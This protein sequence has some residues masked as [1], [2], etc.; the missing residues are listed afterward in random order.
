MK[1]N[2]QRRN[3]LVM[4]G[5]VFSS[6]CISGCGES[7]A[8]VGSKNDLHPTDPSLKQEDGI[9]LTVDSLMIA[10]D[11]TVITVDRA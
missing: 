7:T 10:A 1:F 11:S 4:S 9:I 8:A 2:K 6:I 5:L 3:F